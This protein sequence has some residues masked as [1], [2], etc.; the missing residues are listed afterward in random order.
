[1]I[2]TWLGWCTFFFSSVQFSSVAQLC[3]TLCDPMIC[4]TLK[5]TSIESV[6]PSSH[7]IFCRPLLLL[8]PVPPSIKV[9]THLLAHN[10]L[11]RYS[12]TAWLGSLL[13]VSRG[14]DQGVSHIVS[15]FWVL[16]GDNPL[17]SSLKLLVIISPCGCGTEVTVSLSRASLSS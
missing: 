9:F 6:M 15:L 12:A 1:M 10:S 2:K 7:L 16:W 8:P 14:W 11:V 5:L 17:L 4:S 3:P 13:R